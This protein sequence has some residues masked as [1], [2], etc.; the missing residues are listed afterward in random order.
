MEYLET[1]GA[2]FIG[3]HLVEHKV[4]LGADVRV[5]DNFSTGKHE[6]IAPFSSKIELL[7]GDIVN[8]ETCARACDG[9]RV[10]LHQAAL[11][12]VPKS[13]ADPLSSHRVN[14]DGTFNM[15]LAA[16]DAG[17]QRFVYAASSSA[18]GETPTLPKIESMPSQAL[19]PYAAQKLAGEY[20]CAAFAQCYGLQTF[21][22]RY[23]NVFGSR[24]DPTSQYAAA[25]PEFVT[26]ILRNVPPTVYGDG[27]QTR[28]FTHIENVVHANLLAARAPRANGEVINVA[29][30]QHVTVN[31]I[32]KE[33]NILLGRNVMPEHVAPR[34]GDIKHSWADITLAS[35]V[36]GFKPVVPFAEGLRQTIDWYA[37]NFDT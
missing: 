19:S 18:Y 24:Q 29:C 27:E 32:I 34:P 25:I 6:N 22:L 31:A 30:G 7:E 10:V 26:K 33:I 9:V 11:P 5:L 2:G 37:E 3:S 12:S 4:G 21:S 1:G 20:Y 8:P 13:V 15:L 14:A 23:F 16:R 35:R 28:D 17:V 36:I